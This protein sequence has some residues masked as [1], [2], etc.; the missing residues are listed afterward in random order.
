MPLRRRAAVLASLGLLCLVYSCRK[1]GEERATAPAGGP[2]QLTADEL[3]T[4]L[5]S[6]KG[7]FFLDVREPQEIEL[8]GTI[9]GYVNIPI[10]QLETRLAEIP[11]DKL[12]IT[13]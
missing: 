6:G 2:R 9:R 7:V 4:L 10:S 11:R 8:L 3:K 5:E 1:A 13:A 12:I